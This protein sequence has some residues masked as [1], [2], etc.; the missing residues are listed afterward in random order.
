MTVHIA[1]L[2]VAERK[3]LGSFYTPD[4]LSTVLT[5]WAITSPNDLILEPGFGG[6]GFLTA[7]MNR[8][9]A[10][11][12]PTP[13]RQI[14][15]CDVDPRAYEFLRARIAVEDPMVQFPS[16]DF[17]ASRAKVTWPHLFD[18]V[19][20]NPPYVAYQQLSEDQRAAYRSTLVAYG[21]IDISARASLWAYFVGH[22]LSHLAPGGRAA[23]V[24]PG[25]LLQ[26][27]YAEP[28]KRHLAG[29]FSEVTMLHV[30][31]RLFQSVGAAE[32]TVVLLANGYRSGH[33]TGEVRF[34]SLSTTD[35]LQKYLRR[36]NP[37]AKK[38]D[39][40]RNL[41]ESTLKHR[42]LKPQP[43]GSFLQARI[44]L[45]TGDNPFFVLSDAKAKAHRLPKSALHDV[46]ARPSASAGLSYDADDHLR[47][48]LAGHRVNLVATT[49][50]PTKAGALK[51][52]LDAYPEE[53]LTSVSTFK[54]RKDWFN[55]LDKNVPDAFWPVMRDEGPRLILNYA[56]THCTNT[57]HRIFFNAAVSSSQRK[58]IC[59]AL[60]STYAQL[61]AEIV[62]RS[63]GS[64]VL[65]HE[66]RDVE[67]IKIVLPSTYTE[68]S[69]G[70]VFAA[71][72]RAMR[73][74]KHDLV[75]NL[76]DNFVFGATPNISPKY[77]CK[78]RRHMER[79][80]FM[81]SPRSSKR[82]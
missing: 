28:L 3:R 13:A 47:A 74:G 24:L 80:R 53:K 42:S 6:C 16:M 82:I 11:G 39:Q 56:N 63:Y 41:P 70:R 75:R 15:G 81:R 52:Y 66:P 78:L 23:W 44:G 9:I 46:L 60:Q 34:A 36:G 54:K 59:I 65:K 32:E 67:N 4:S 71:I 58:A 48:G 17:M 49:K 14:F 57:L 10:V 38:L 77:L 22:A 51:R 37:E 2:A 50:F 26:A 69:V 27:N 61:S 40:S 35:A 68:G 79:M 1:P 31:E 33:A 20:G 8:L 5:E 45:V 64:G 30:H 18:V 72:D 43:L 25:S 29:H 73:S 62:G 76:A 19:I 12:C 7:S 21:F 55:P